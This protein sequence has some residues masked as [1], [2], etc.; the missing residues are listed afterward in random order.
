[1]RVSSR[2][3]VSKMQL[4]TA[5]GVVASPTLT[6]VVPSSVPNAMLQEL[7]NHRASLSPARFPNDKTTSVALPN[8]ITRAFDCCEGEH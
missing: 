6:T 2:E 5:R 1:M 3:Q 8:E 4:R 7:N